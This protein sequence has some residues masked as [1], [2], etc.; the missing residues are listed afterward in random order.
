MLFFNKYGN[1]FEK[2]DLFIK[3]KRMGICLKKYPSVLIKYPLKK[4][5]KSS[6]RNVNFLKFKTKNTYFKG[7]NKI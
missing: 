5:I 1:L 6:R 2:D 4:I 3:N 7:Y